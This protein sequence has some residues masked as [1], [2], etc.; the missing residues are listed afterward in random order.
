MRAPMYENDG[1]V[2]VTGGAGFIGSHLA[3]TLLS[4]GL[5]IHVLDNLSNGNAEHIKRW[6][7]N[8]RF[9][10]YDFDLLDSVSLDL[11]PN[12]KIVYHLAN[13]AVMVNAKNLEFHLNQNIAAIFNLLN[14][15]RK[16]DTAV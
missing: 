14:A 10:F 4:Q 12:Y 8:P 9:K 11:L 2:L 13:P 1:P 6:K 3:E 15:V 5:E 7:V 16:W